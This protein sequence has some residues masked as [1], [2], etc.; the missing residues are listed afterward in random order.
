[1]LCQ[2]FHCPVTNK[3]S[4]DSGL[5]LYI[6]FYNYWGVCKEQGGGGGIKVRDIIHTDPHV[7][8]VCKNTITVVAHKR[9]S[10]VFK[11]FQIQ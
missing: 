9:C 7:V 5:Q 4:P 10:V 1:M 2:P 8:S 11:R 6:H 3:I